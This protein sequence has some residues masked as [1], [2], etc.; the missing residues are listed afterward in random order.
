MRW[1]KTIPIYSAK[2]YRRARR[3]DVLVV[4]KAQNTHDADAL[5]PAMKVLQFGSERGRRGAAHAK[6]EHG[7]RKEIPQEDQQ[8]VRVH[9]DVAHERDDDAAERYERLCPCRS[10]LQHTMN[11][12]I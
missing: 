7:H 12:Y 9:D 2:Q 3:N 1:C 5:E 10:H 11:I 6:D 4:E 8:V